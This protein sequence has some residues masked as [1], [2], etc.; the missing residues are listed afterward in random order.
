MM[1]YSLL[2]GIHDPDMMD[3]VDKTPSDEDCAFS[4]GED[5]DTVNGPPDD[6]VDSAGHDSEGANVTSD[7]EITGALQSTGKQGDN[8]CKYFS[9]VTLIS[10]CFYSSI[11]DCGPIFG[12]VIFVSVR[13]FDLTDGVIGV[14]FCIVPITLIAPSRFNNEY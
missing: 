12:H 4:P 6:V 7:S 3:K 1:S 10:I 9:I 5:D 13:G 8:C 14:S 11:I 2:V